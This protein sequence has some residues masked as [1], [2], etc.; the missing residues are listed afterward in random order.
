VRSTGPENIS[1]SSKMIHLL[2][3]GTHRDTCSPIHVEM[4]EIL[5][6]SSSSFVTD[7]LLIEKLGPNKFDF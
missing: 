5:I 4:G 6:P 1:G 7:K 3:E 2:N